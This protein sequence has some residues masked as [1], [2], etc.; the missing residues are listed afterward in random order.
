MYVAVIF[1][2]PA[3]TLSFLYIYLILKRIT[4]IYIVVGGQGMF[5][6][7]TNLHLISNHKPQKML[8]GFTHFFHKLS[9]DYTCTYSLFL[10]ICSQNS[11]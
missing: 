1:K 10:H 9:Q 6:V 11:Q 3:A 7:F 2:S 5:P 4:Y 8:F